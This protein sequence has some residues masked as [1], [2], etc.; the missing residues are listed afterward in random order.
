MHEFWYP[1]SGTRSTY[2]RNTART[3]SADLA[4]RTRAIVLSSR[5]ALSSP[6]L[7]HHPLHREQA[8]RATRPAKPSGSVRRGET[9]CSGFFILRNARKVTT[10]CLRS[11]LTRSDDIGTTA[12]SFLGTIT[13]KPSSSSAALKFCRRMRGSID[14]VG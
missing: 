7:Q 4:Q 14:G 5:K 2:S 6:F 12:L 10:K 1:T 3:S 9:E 8:V 11:R 13:G